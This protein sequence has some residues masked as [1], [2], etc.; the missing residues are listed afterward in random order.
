MHSVAILACL[1]LISLP[2]LQLGAARF[3]CQGT[4]PHNSGRHATAPHHIFTLQ[5]QQARFFS[6]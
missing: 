6:L 5:A 1:Q 3:L 4:A 2:Q